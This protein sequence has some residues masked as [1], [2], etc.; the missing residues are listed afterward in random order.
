MNFLS[1]ATKDFHWLASPFARLSACSPNLPFLMNPFT[2]ESSLLQ[3][4]NLAIHEF[5]DCNYGP[6]GDDKL[7]EQISAGVDLEETWGDQSETPL[8][9]ATRRYRTTAVEILLDHGAN[10]DA[11]N[12]AGKTAYAHAARRSFNDLAEVLKKRGADVSLTAADEL[13]IAVVNGKLDQAKLIIGSNPNCVCTGNP[14]EDRLLADVAGRNEIEPVRFLINAGAD[15]ANSRGLDG[16]TALHQAAWFGQP[17]NARLLI[18]AGALLDDFDPTHNY[19]PLGWAVHGSRYSGGAD[20]RQAVYVELV[21]MLLT[22]G[23]SLQ[24]P[25]DDSPKYREQLLKDATDEVK[26]VL[27]KYL[28]SV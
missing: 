26:I 18:D 22:A 14:E 1:P 27:Q 20:E 13:A 9:V 16:A 8:H 19:S 17:Q 7:K 25:G 5:L 3:G 21:E 24:Q 23:S 2:T 11:K 10:I 4:A 28:D 15:V 6:D 12:G